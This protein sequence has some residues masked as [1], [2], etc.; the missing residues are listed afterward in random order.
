MKSSLPL[1]VLIGGTFL[2]SLFSARAQTNPSLPGTWT[3]QFQEEFSGTRVDGTKWHLGQHWSGMAG[4]GGVAPENVTVDNGTLKIKSEQRAISYGGTAYSYATGELSTFSKFRQQYGYFEARV[5]YPAVTGLWPA[6]WFMPDRAAYGWTG[7]YQQ[8]YLKFNLSGTSISPV[9]SA[10]LK[11]KVSAKDNANPNNVVVMRLQDDSWTET[12]ITWNNKPT[13]DPV[14]IAQAWNQATVGQVISVD[15]TSYVNEQ[16][17]GD[18]KISFVL[19]DTFMKANGITFYSR[20]AANQADRPQLVING[21]TYYATEDATVRWGDYAS[22]NYGTAGT[23]VAK[24]DWGDTATTFNGGMEI[25]TMETLGIWGPNTIQHALHW[26]G[27]GASHQTTGWPGI[28]FPAS[29][30]GFHTYGVYWQ[31]GLLEFYVDG[32]RTAQWANSRVMSVPAYMILSLQLGGW[33]N[34]NPG[35]QDQ[36]QQ[37]EVDWVRAWSGTRAAATT[38]TVDNLNAAATTST[39]TWTASTVTGGYYATNYV[40]DNNTNKGSSTFSFNPPLTADSEYAVYARW[41]SGTNR[42]AAVPID[43]TSSNATVKTVTV[44]QQANG[45]KWNLLGGFTLSPV[46]AR[47]T[48]KN[49]GTT[50][51]VVADAVQCVPVG[52]GT[53]IIVD[54]TDAATSF[55]GTWTASTSTPTY[56]GTNYVNDGNTAKGAKTFSYSPALPANGDYFIYARWTAGSNRASNVPIDIV[57]STGAVSTV[58]VNQRANDGIWVLLGAYPLATA[59]AKVTIRTTSTDGYVIADAIKLIPVSSQ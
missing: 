22:T 18:K 36:N 46:N 38:V 44:N 28:T 23:L 47:I 54:N 13:P 25:D 39:G 53:S 43:L 35:A 57:T 34:N 29:G 21:T 24:D 48:V 27:Y 8:A 32:I 19:A 40:H 6:F 1:R 9:T 41:T 33:D 3:L 16:M 37:M 31:S 52:S 5:K 59:N 51:F 55:T 10:V 49:V 12:G 14:W 45:G 26:D 17:A 4:S 56:Y 58:Q 2:L 20:E 50:G 42:A 7:A 15:V 11:V 30:D